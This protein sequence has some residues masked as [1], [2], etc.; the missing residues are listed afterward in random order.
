MIK[1]IRHIAINV[2][3]IDSV[4]RKFEAYGLPCTERIEK[5]DLGQRIAFAPIGDTLIEFIS[6]I[7]PNKVQADFHK[8]VR[9]ITGVINHIC[10]EVDDLDVSI[11]DFE[12]VGAKQVEGSPKPG[13]HGRVALFYPESTEGVLIELCQV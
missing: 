9:G 8:V 10:F 12:R 7:D 4:V 2:K 3:D 6:F 13:A 5:E 1:K 11:K